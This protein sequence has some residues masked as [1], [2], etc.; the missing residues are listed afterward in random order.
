MFKDFEDKLDKFFQ[1]DSE[2]L[3]V[4]KVSG[5]WDVYI[6]IISKSENEFQEK[7]SKL[8]ILC[9]GH[10]QNFEVLNI[11][12]EFDAQNIPISFFG[13]NKIKINYPFGRVSPVKEIIDIDKK[14]TQIIEIISKNA[15]TPTVKIA[16]S[17][18]LSP[19][20]IH[21][22]IKRLTEKN[23]IKGYSLV[24]DPTS[25]KNSVYLVFVELKGHTEKQ[26]Q[27]FRQSLLNQPQ[28]NDVYKIGYKYD[29]LFY[30]Q[31]ENP[32]EFNNTL[33]HIRTKFSDIIKNITAVSE[34]KEYKYTEFPVQ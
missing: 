3:K 7:L 32:A 4:H 20:A 11:F 28:I 17:I 9:E 12:E 25:I 15:R 33:M 10:M 14:D 30:L 5:S 18:N 13:Q 24:F 21:N 16:N 29:Y 1:E 34:L 2:I 26:E 22:R 6:D 27:E 31:A 8:K 19:D 23:I